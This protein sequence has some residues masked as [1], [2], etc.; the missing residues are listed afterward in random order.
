MPK[1]KI[2]YWQTGNIKF[3]NFK[4]YGKQERIKNMVR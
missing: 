3:G 4:N 1:N 2:P